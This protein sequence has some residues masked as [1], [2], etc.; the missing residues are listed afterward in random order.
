MSSSKKAYGME[1]SRHNN[2]TIVNE[3]MFIL[4]QTEYSQ[5]NQT[6]VRVEDFTRQ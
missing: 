6:V 2:D 1:Q 3:L 5:K 4:N